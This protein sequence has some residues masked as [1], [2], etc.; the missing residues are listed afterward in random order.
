MFLYLFAKCR[1]TGELAPV[2]AEAVIDLVG[3]DI[4]IAADAHLCKRFQLLFGIDHAGRVGRVIEH[5][6]LCF[7]RNGGLQ[8]LRRHFEMLRLGRRNDHRNAADH[9]DLL[10]IADPVRRGNNNFVTSIEQCEERSIQASLSTVRDNNG[11]IVKIHAK[12]F[13]HPVCNGFACLDSTGRWRILRLSFSNG[14][15]SR[16]LDMVGRIKIRLPC[17]KAYDGDTLRLHLLEFRVDR[18]RCG[19]R[20]GGTD[21]G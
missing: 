4:D 8:L 12:I 14:A 15:N 9:A 20:D 11:V 19:R 5:E 6:R 3:N 13:L 2:V 7:V 16:F 17:P 18:Q 21:F 10:G 1:N